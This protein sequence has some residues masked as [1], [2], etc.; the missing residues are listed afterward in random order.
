M[1]SQRALFLLIELAARRPIIIITIIIIIISIIASTI[2]DPANSTQGL[3]L[4]EIHAR[5]SMVLI[6]G[7]L[8][9]SLQ[10]R[11]KNPEKIRHLL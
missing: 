3:Q 7:S 4:Q 6:G 5:E 2:L 1:D 10:M 9:I 8:E 11:V